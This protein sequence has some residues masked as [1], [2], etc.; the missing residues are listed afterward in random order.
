MPPRHFPIFLAAQAGRALV[1]GTGRIAAHKA[2]TLRSYGF[3]VES[4]APGDFTA[5]MLPDCLLVVAATRD[6]EFNR[7]V[8]EACRAA[9]VLVNVVDA[10]ELCTCCFA[11]VERQGPFTVAVSSNG[12]CPV[13][14]QGLRD[15]IRPLLTAD[16]VATAERLGRD[17]AAWKAQYPD[18]ARRAAAMRREFTAGGGPADAGA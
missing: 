12:T 15:R 16:L 13:A 18:P 17:R 9:R 10:P 8:S 4:C 2:A 1:I 7:R 14:A 5:A 3:A 11:A 6:A